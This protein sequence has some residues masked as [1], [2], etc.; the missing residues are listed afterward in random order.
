[1]HIKQLEMLESNKKRVEV[2]EEKV[3]HLEQCV[4]DLDANYDKIYKF[5]LEKSEVV[6]RL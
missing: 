2:L 6:R 5:M 4:K 3:L 1:M